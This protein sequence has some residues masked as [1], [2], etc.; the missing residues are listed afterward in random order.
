MRYVFG[1][2]FGLLELQV[3]L[4]RLNVFGQPKAQVAHLGAPDLKIGI[5]AKAVLPN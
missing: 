2:D 4:Y 1:N 3:N 5:D